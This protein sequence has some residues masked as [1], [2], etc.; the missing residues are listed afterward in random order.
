M[1]IRLSSHITGLKICCKQDAFPRKLLQAF[2]KFKKHISR[3]SGFNENLPMLPEQLER[4][5][6]EKSSTQTLV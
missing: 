5:L 3:P 1:L 4:K 6:K 2:V